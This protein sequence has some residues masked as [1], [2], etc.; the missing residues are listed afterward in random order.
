MDSSRCQTRRYASSNEVGHA[1]AEGFKYVLG[2]GMRLEKCHVLPVR[3]H[4]IS[5]PVPG[6]SSS[7]KFMILFFDS[8]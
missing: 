7:Y 4:G 1:T 3:R 6:R 8:L 5:N 2:P